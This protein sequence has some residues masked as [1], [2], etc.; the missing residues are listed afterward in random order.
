MSSIILTN[1][2]YK[3]INMDDET[4]LLFKKLC[5]LNDTTMREQLVGFIERYNKKHIKRIK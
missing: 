5:T 1:M 3:A 2:S 4:W